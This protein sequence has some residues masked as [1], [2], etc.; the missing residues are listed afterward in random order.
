MA[1]DETSHTLLQKGLA[2]APRAPEPPPPPRSQYFESFVDFVSDKDL[3]E[4]AQNRNEI[5]S[6]AKEQWRTEQQEGAKRDLELQ[7]QT[8]AKQQLIK[9]DGAPHVLVALAGEDTEVRDY[10]VRLV[11]ARGPEGR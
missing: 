5:A 3:H 8:Q 1:K 7:R 11:A 6:F 10:L 4:G 2:P 9:A